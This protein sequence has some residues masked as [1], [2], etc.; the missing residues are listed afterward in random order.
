MPFGMDFDAGYRN[1]AYVAGDLPCG[2][3]VSDT[4][5][6]YVK[7]H[8]DS[9]LCVLALARK[10]GPSTRFLHGTIRRGVYAC[11]L[12]FRLFTEYRS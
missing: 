9:C 6:G 11:P 1:F 8:T 5:S 4:N 12:W 2:R 3:A 10:D 7:W